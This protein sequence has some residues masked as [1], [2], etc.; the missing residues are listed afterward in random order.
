MTIG[1]QDSNLRISIEVCRAVPHSRR[2]FQA[3][4]DGSGSDSEMQR[5]ESCRLNRPVRVQCVLNRTALEMS[6]Y[7]GISLRPGFLPI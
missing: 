4:I 2:K 7:R 6:R 3:M 5:F 1:R